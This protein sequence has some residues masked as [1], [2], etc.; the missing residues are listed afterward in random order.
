MAFVAQNN[1]KSRKS[2]LLN[3]ISPKKV[4][5]LDPYLIEP[6]P[7]QPR[8][9]FDKDSITSLAKDIK[10]DGQHQPIV[11]IDKDGKYILVM[12]ERRVKACKEIGVEVEAIIN[13]SETDNLEKELAYMRR[14]ALMEN[15]QR[16]KLSMIE[17]A[18]SYNEIL[19]NDDSINNIKELAEYLNFSYSGVRRTMSILKLPKEILEMIETKQCDISE[20]MVQ[21]LSSL[22][23][24]EMMLQFKALCSKDNEDKKIEQKKEKEKKQ[25][26]KKTHMIKSNTNSFI[27]SIDKK[28][29]PE[30]YKEELSMFEELLK[31]FLKK[32]EEESN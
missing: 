32:I 29:I 2:R 15:M 10:R 17:K 19:D 6:N 3:S 8:K 20:K 1:A 18:N 27:F 22:D 4:V 23:E 13:T 21:K 7:H 12:G 5:K 24:K 30:K 11:V 26:P 14:A 25:V 9:N 28:T 31:D 16:E